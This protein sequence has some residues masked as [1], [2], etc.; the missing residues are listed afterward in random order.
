MKRYN[1]SLRLHGRVIENPGPLSMPPH[2]ISAERSEIDA[3]AAALSESSPA[4]AFPSP[5]ASPVLKLLWLAAAVVV[6][7]A[8]TLYTQHIWEDYFI[9]FR[10]SRNLCLGNGLVYNI[11]ERV[12]GFTSPL[13]VLLPAGAYALFAQ[14]SYLPALWLFRV[15]SIVAFAGGGLLLIRRLEE[16]HRGSVLPGL[17]FGVLYLLDAKS[18]AFSTNGMETAF[19]LFFLAWGLSLFDP[20]GRQRWLLRGLCWAGLMWTRPDGFIYIAALALAQWLFTEVPR[21]RLIRPLFLSGLVCTVLYLPWF[22]WAWQYYGSPVPHT[23][24]A[25]SLF[26]STYSVHLRAMI[27]NFPQFLLHR[28][29]G[30]YTPVYFKEFGGWPTWIGWVSSALGLLASVY[31]LLPLRDRFG[32]MA[33]LC[34]TLLVGYSLLIPTVF[35]WY[36]PPAA[37]CGSLVLAQGFFTL[38][39]AVRRHLRLTRAVASLALASVALFMAS[40]L[41]ASA[42]ELRIQQRLIEDE[43]RVAIGLWLKTQMKDGDRV[44][45]EPIGYIG[46]FSEARILDWL[47]LV[48]PEVI[49][50]RRQGLEYPEMIPVLNA[51]WVSL[52]TAGHHLDGADQ[53]RDGIRF[54]RRTTTWSVSLTAATSWPTVRRC[55]V[56]IG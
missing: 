4:F 54:H 32:R 6:P 48:S 5:R 10:C 40:V 28:L 16:E 55:R 49:R 44:F 37:M 36:Y 18:I 41:A 51:E 30:L 21:L 9:T 38:A 17:F 45:L 53:G 42:W 1:G 31:W 35:P 23:I 25:K 52:A 12:H 19:M 33:S 15:V 13:G 24:I 27:G 2:P 43:N 7:L 29:A 22:V 39:G 46:Y 56:G 14:D 3:P 26:G 20:D 47:G 8:F 11:G 34:F 50:L